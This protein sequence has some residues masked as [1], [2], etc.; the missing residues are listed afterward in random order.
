MQGEPMWEGY[1]FAHFRNYPSVQWKLLNLA[2]LKKQ[3]PAKLTAEAEKL[4]QVL[5]QLK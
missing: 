2:K 3:N 5:S 1:E 4:Q